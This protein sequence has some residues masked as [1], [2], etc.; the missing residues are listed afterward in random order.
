M[1]GKGASIAFPNGNELN[2][3]D[4]FGNRSKFFSLTRTRKVRVTP[5]GEACVE[6]SFCFYAEEKLSHVV[7]YLLTLWLPIE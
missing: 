5:N 4:K 2:Y 1:H 3:D 7:D 6:I